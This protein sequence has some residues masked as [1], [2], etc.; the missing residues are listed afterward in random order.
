M[1]LAVI[2]SNVYTGFQR[3]V[4]K[5]RKFIGDIQGEKRRQITDGFDV[6]TPDDP[7]DN[8]RNHIYTFEECY[9]TCA[10]GSYCDS[11]HYNVNSVSNHNCYIWEK[12]V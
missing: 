2:E 7:Y 3:G 9:K 1:K 8:K 11:F 5:C 10:E 12:D 6:G 4:G